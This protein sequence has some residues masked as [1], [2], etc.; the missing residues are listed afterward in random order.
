ML[1]ISYQQ[2]SVAYAKRPISGYVPFFL[3]HLLIHC[4][5]NSLSTDQDRTRKSRK[6]RLHCHTTAAT[7]KTPI[8]KSNRIIT[9][10]CIPV[11]T[12]LKAIHM[13]H[14]FTVIGL[15]CYIVLGDT[16]GTPNVTFVFV[17]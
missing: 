3:H 17:N 13:L 12:S 11:H 8:Y 4:F 1:P 14:R 5:G 7:H 10:N 2:K 9:Y 16:C 6:A 15:R